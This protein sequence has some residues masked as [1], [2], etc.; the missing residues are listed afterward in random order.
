MAGQLLQGSQVNAGA[1]AQRQV[2]MPQAMEVGVKGTV[3][4][5]HGIRDAGGL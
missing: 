2:G 3:W 5:F 4:A 1:G